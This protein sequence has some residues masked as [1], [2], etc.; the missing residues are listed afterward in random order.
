MG[1]QR[2][3]S[4][5][6]RRWWNW[7]MGGGGK[8]IRSSWETREQSW[9]ALD[10]NG[11]RQG[12]FSPSCRMF[13][14]EYRHC[15]ED[16]QKLTVCL[17]TSPDPHKQRLPPQTRTAACLNTTDA[18][19]QLKRGFHQSYPNGRPNTS[20]IQRTVDHIFCVKKDR[21]TTT[22][23]KRHDEEGSSL[24]LQQS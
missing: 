8:H 19:F 17:S 9:I 21:G 24:F 4:D 14:N 2:T 7:G 11:V 20:T 10:G 16:I 5:G 6:S 1:N 12:S 23:V 13:G 3:K 18:F 15:H 22:S